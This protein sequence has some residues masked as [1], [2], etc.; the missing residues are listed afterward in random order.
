MRT[1]V[2]MTRKAKNKSVQF[3]ADNFA[4]W[5]CPFGLVI[6]EWFIILFSWFKASKLNDG[7]LTSAEEWVVG[8][9]SV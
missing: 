5:E 3:L 2:L 7:L 1:T 9:W 8:S 6:F 4:Q